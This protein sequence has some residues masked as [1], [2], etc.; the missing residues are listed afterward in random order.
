[1]DT[2]SLS[3]IGEL[4]HEDELWKF[5]F[6]DQATSHNLPAIQDHDPICV[7]I[8]G[9]PKGLT[10][11][12]A[13]E[14][15]RTILL[16][17]TRNN[18]VAQHSS[19]TVLQ[20]IEQ[21][22]VPGYVASKGL[23]GRMYYRSMLKHI[24]DPEVID[25]IFCLGPGNGNARLRS[26]QGW[27]YL[28]PIRLVDVRP[29]TVQELTSVALVRGYSTQ[30]VAH[31][32]SVVRTIFAYAMQQ[33]YFSGENPA[34]PVQ[35]PGVRINRPE[36]PALTH[37]DVGRLLSFMDYPEKEMTLI[38]IVTGMTIGEI[39][40]LRWKQ[41]NLAEKQ[42]IRSEHEVIPPMTI[43]IRE[44]WVRSQLISVPKRRRLNCKIPNSLLPVLQRL[45]S[46]E[47]FTGLEDF[48]LVS[49]VGSPVNSSN[50]L[51]RKLK[52]IGREMKIPWLSWQHLRGIHR[53]L[54][55]E[56]G[57][58]FH[59]HMEGLVHEAFLPALNNFGNLPHIVET[60]LP[61]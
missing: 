61:Y 42:M 17:K 39:C 27:P 14:V 41:V 48:V 34:R 1:M 29:E 60:E 11:T 26:V 8:L 49:R 4:Y 25:R 54:L 10:R 50:I 13:Q 55:A 20:F 30:T 3:E 52:F 28:G 18:A 40:G 35:L 38:T 53:A 2:N 15:V 12:E 16:A 57:S 31:M 19:M 43:V 9:G 23:F 6:H 7:G 21:N 59:D 36:L 46:R 56:F 33:M 44:E 37:A 47:E 5:R 58:S 45:K 32:R 24:V 51:N 22:F